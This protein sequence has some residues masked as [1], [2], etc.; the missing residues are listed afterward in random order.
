MFKIWMNGVRIFNKDLPFYGVLFIVGFGISAWL[1]FI[2][3][4]DAK[5]DGDDLTYASIFA[6]IGGILGAKF[7]SMM[8]SMQYLIDYI[9]AYGFSFDALKIFIQNGF[10]FYGG[11]LGGIL[12]LFLYCKIYKLPA[13]AF[14]DLFAPAVPLG[15]A[16]G[17]LGCLFS[18][19]CYGQPAFG[20]LSV[21]YLRSADPNTPLNTPLIPIQLIESLCLLVIFACCTF[22]FR[23][24]KKT[25]ETT[26]TYALSYGILRFILEFFRG[27]AVRGVY[28]F[29]TSQYISMG[30]VVFC[31]AWMLLFGREERKD[32]YLLCPKDRI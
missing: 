19:C 15:H 32:K 3:R 23:N 4:S 10:V 1:I 9:N 2:H 29:S 6:G 24:S 12:G 13:M 5:I 7:L 27:D 25:G 31:I 26:M 28:V 20:W 17:R 14:F 18:G 8:T 11:L 22:V 16:L 30:I 21:I